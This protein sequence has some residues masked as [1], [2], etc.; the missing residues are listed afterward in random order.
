MGKKISVDSA[1]MMNKVFEVI[2]AKKIFN[3]PY[4]KISILIHPKSYVHA[5]IQFN[6]GMINMITHETTMEIPIFNTLNDFTSSGNNL[7]SKNFKKL[8]FDKLNN[9][10][11]SQ[12]SSMK[13]PVV[14]ILNKLPQKDSLFETILV[15]ANDEFVNLFLHK[16]ISYIELIQ[17]LLKY[18]LKK[19]FV[20]YKRIEPKKITDILELNKKIRLQINTSC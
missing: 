12:I 5:I 10:N 11:L 1:T 13:F 15:S 17:K 9:L 14:D 4:K 19:E 20:K 2:E 18:V 7:S 6:D 16:K 3:L 8:N